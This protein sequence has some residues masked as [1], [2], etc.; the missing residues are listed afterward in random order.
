M[1]K[2][3]ASQN[4]DETSG[5]EIEQ[6]TSTSFAERLDYLCK[7]DP[8]GPFSD[9]QVATMLQE[10]GLPTASSTYIWQLRK[11]KRDNPT[12]HH[13]EGFAQLF[14]VPVDYFFKQDTAQVVNTLLGMLNHLK[15]K[16]V[17]AEQLHT[18]LE[19]L[20]RLLEAGVTPDQVVTQLETLQRLNEAGVTLDTLNRFEDAG[21]KSVAMRAVGLSR[22][23]L[24]A[25]LTM[26]AQV[27][28][29]EGLPP[30]PDQDLDQH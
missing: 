14:G 24:D 30:E 13:I 25:A 28:R 29:L 18:Q 23:G 5:V 6:A 26:I 16:G 22:Q 1:T 20:S 21:V 15:E 3:H 2:A 11:N 7:N 12:K 9:T 17:T 4:D 10:A 8:R 19:S 27:R